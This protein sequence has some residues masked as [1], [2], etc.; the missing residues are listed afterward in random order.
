M[1]KNYT[2]ELREDQWDLILLCLDH[3]RAMANNAVSNYAVDSVC[4]KFTKR[5]VDE[6]VTEITANVPEIK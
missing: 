1:T 2:V 3:V 5:R 4:R 6:I